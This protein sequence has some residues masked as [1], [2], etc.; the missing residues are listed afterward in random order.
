MSITIGDTLLN[1]KDNLN[2]YIIIYKQD[3]NLILDKYI[4]NIFC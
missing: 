4:N 3:Y 1:Y 2:K